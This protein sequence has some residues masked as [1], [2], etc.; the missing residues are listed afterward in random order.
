MLT[1]TQLRTG[2]VSLDR[3]LAGSKPRETSGGT[4]S[5]CA[6]SLYQYQ[7]GA[8]THNDPAAKDSASLTADNIAG[9]WETS[10][11]LLAPT[12]P[13]A[14]LHRRTLQSKEPQSS[15]KDR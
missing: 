7:G 1:R 5:S 13:G 6:A 2:M 11:T 3:E 8:T 4:A 15:V 10:G 12:T 14:L 9:P